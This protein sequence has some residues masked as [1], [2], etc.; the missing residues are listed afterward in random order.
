M[1]VGS[2]DRRGPRQ[3]EGRR[4]WEPPRRGREER[5]VGEGGPR[6]LGPGL[7]V[8]EGAEEGPE[9]VGALWASL[10]SAVHPVVLAGSPRLLGALCPVLCPV[11]VA[12][13]IKL[14]V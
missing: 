9:R 1:S 2:H 5:G 11:C 13:G 3:V 14:R 4:V 8:G 12:E 10:S 7:C 6:R